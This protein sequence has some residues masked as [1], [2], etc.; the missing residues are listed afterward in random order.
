MRKKE[1]EDGKYAETIRSL[2]I[3]GTRIMLGFCVLAALFVAMQVLLI[4]CQNTNIF[5][6]KVDISIVRTYMNNVAGFI[7]VLLFV[8]TLIGAAMIVHWLKTEVKVIN[9]MDMNN[10]M[11]T[12]SFGRQGTGINMQMTASLEASEQPENTPD[13][14]K[15]NEESNEIGDVVSEEAP[16]SEIG[17]E[18][19]AAIQLSDEIE[20][21]QNDIAK[22]EVVPGSTQE[23]VQIIDQNLDGGNPQQSGLNNQ[24]DQ[25]VQ[26]ISVDVQALM[27]QEEETALRPSTR[28]DV[29]LDNTSALDQAC[30]ECGALIIPMGGA[31]VIDYPTQRGIT[32]DQA[33]EM[34][35]ADQKFWAIA[36]NFGLL[37]QELNRA[38][39][40]VGLTIDSVKSYVE[41]DA[42][43]MFA[44]QA[45]IDVGV[46][47]GQCA[48]ACL[49][50]K[51]QNVSKM[52]KRHAK[53]VTQTGKAVD[54]AQFPNS[55]SIN[56]SNLSNTGQIRLGKT[57]IIR[58]TGY[59]NTNRAAK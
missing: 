59:N 30:R 17:Q 34:D 56:S 16:L 5:G 29:L 53:I 48:E 26:S 2:Q 41:I 15:P 13:A 18:L 4:C 51:S 1:S 57:G 36:H 33:V 25:I 45:I 3:M 22:V 58:I 20:T 54:V 44:R 14:Q 38:L 40:L 8:I 55:T 23:M 37:P 39:S 24:L 9:V 27:Q 42:L 35:N 12:F 6:D 10:R 43:W 49:K 21:S 28:S 31:P 46:R 11:I 7:G 47:D 19:S 52:A 50:V 32:L